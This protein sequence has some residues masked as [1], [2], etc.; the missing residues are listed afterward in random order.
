MSVV[1]DV[2]MARSPFLHNNTGTCQLCNIRSVSG[3][4]SNGKKTLHWCA[5]WQPGRQRK[6]FEKKYQ[7]HITKAHSSGHYCNMVCLQM[8]HPYIAIAMQHGLHGA[9]AELHNKCKLGDTISKQTTMCK[10]IFEYINISTC[11]RSCR[12]RYMLLTAYC[13]CS[14]VCRVPRAVYCVVMSPFHYEP[15][16]YLMRVHLDIL[17]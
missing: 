17:S 7:L 15:T 8:L 16:T 4:S 13:L 3:L 12:Y 5:Q 10:Q 6:H 1:H 14:T 11:I 2:D 9:S